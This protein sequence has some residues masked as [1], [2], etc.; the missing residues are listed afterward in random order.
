MGFIRPDS[1]KA[2]FSHILEPETLERVRR[3]RNAAALVLGISTGVSAAGEIIDNT[4]IISLVGAV[5]AYV[6]MLR[7]Y[8]TNELLLA[9]DNA[10]TQFRPV[11]IP[12]MQ[13]DQQVQE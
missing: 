12:L 11:D 9:H 7:L 8:R 6:Q 5:G 1:E 13:T 3:A 10:V 2:M 4:G